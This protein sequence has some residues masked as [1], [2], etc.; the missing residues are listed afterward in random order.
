MAENKY[1]NKQIIKI[2]SKSEKSYEENIIVEKKKLGW[3]G[4]SFYEVS[5]A[6][7]SER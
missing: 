2:I 1:F 5:R 3:V 6:A 4:G 7:I